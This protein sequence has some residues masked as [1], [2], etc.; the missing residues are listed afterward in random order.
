MLVSLEKKSQSGL[1]VEFYD[2]VSLTESTS[3]GL[4]N[5]G[6]LS[7]EYFVTPVLRYGRF[8]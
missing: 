7:L 4:I 8:E 1:G 2:D 5:K 3:V 6:Q